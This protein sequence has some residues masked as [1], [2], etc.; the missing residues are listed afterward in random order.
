MSTIPDLRRRFAYDEWANREVLAALRAATPAP[1][2]ALDRM[3]HVLSAQHVWFDRLRQQAQTLPVWPH[4]TLPE[5]EREAAKLAG[6]WKD[7]LGAL[8][9]AD[10]SGS[11]TYKNTKGE[12]WTSRVDDILMHVILH[13]AYHR[14]QI[15]SDLRAAGFTPASTDFIYAIRQ[16]FVA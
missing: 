7:Y 11:V 1:P 12:P 2:V 9:E 13:S 5:C 8:A 6:L 15:A 10:L 4:F 14:G 3:A 16:G